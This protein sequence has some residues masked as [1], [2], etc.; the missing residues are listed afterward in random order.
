M[1]WFERRP[2]GEARPHTFGETDGAVREVDFATL[3]ASRGAARPAPVPAVPAAPLADERL[4]PGLPEEAPH[5]GAPAD[6]TDEPVVAREPALDPAA[7]DEAVEVR[8]QAIAEERAR[9]QWAGMATEL[10]AFEARASADWADQVATVAAAVTRHLV[11]EALRIDPGRI[12]RAV[13]HGLDA[14][15]GLGEATVHVHPQT[16]ADVQRALSERGRERNVVADLSVP[17]GSCRI[18]TARGGVEVDVAD[19]VERLAEAAARALA[20]S[21]RPANANVESTGEA[22]RTGTGEPVA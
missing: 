18:T 2:D 16:V 15:D 17:Y 14:V 6:A 21:D 11:G 12:A 3:H 10:A 22:R 8:A 4:E 20:T 13:E 1:K 9:E 19:R 5:D 7:F